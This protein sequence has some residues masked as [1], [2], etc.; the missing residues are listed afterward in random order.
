MAPEP[1]EGELSKRAALA[2]AIAATPGGPARTAT[3]RPRRPRRRARAADHDATPGLASRHALAAR[4]APK[5]LNHSMTIS[6]IQLVFHPGRA[7]Q[8]EEPGVDSFDFVVVG[9]G[10]AGCVLAARLSED[11][12]V[13]VLLLEAGAGAPPAGA[14]DPQAWLS[15]VT[16]TASTGGVPRG[17]PITSSTDPIPRGRV[18][19]GSSAIN[20][21]IFVRG[22]WSSYDRWAESGA[23][24]WGFADLLPYFRRSESAPA[25]DPAIRGTAG[26][27]AV[28]PPNPGN[29]VFEA[30]LAAAEEAGHPRATDISGGLEEGFGQ[31]DLN[32]V[33]GRRQSAL[34]AY[35]APA[36]DRAN[37]RVLTETLVHRVLVNHGRCDGV[38]YSA[39]GELVR[40]GCT[41]E[42]VLTAGTIGSAQLLQRSG[43]GPAAALRPHGIEVIA[44]LPGVGENLQDHPTVSLVYAPGQ[45]VPTGKHN[46][47]EALGLLRTNPGLDHP[48]LQIAFADIPVPSPGGETAT[49]LVLMTSLMQPF[50]SGTV[51]LSGADPDAAPVVTPRYLIDPRDLDAMVNGLKLARELPLTNALKPWYAQEIVPGPDTG[52]AA[53][54]AYATA[55]VSTSYHPVGTCRIGTDD[56][57]VVDPELRVH[58]ISGL[59]IADASV[60]PSIVSG[61]TNATVYAIAER[62]AALIRPTQGAHQ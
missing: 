26:P 22:H 52:D 17:Q 51:R 48:D 24:G 61:N 40:T 16:S 14:D 21:M 19:G 44:D 41:G 57:A 53:L 10:S 43:I 28:A 39:G 5:Y 46:H 27:L 47:I 20:G 30:G 59:R 29:P 34:D 9:G 3:T 7:E 2:E 25:R 35:L 62:A 42:V 33:A 31:P 36:A 58:G 32:I 18:L 49:I 60:M 15:L 23:K 11:P 38:E 37:L 54:S 8:T 1:Q 12:E 56:L 13:S 4:V 45:P 55:A 50:S 6:T